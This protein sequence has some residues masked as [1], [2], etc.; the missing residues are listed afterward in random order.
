MVPD[1]DI[2]MGLLMQ[3]GFAAASRCGQAFLELA[4]L[5]SPALHISS[6]MVL[7]HVLAA[8]CGSRLEQARILANSFQLSSFCLSS[9]HLASTQTSRMFCCC[10]CKWWYYNDVLPETQSWALEML[11][12]A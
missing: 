7:P 11:L 3:G 9:C 12:G 2:G 6:W 10:C 5:V 8:A 1:N 4:Q